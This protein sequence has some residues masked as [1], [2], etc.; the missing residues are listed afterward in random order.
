MCSKMLLQ[1]AV[2]T[3]IANVPSQQRYLLV[4][5][6]DNE[7]KKLPP[8]VRNVGLMGP[9]RSKDEDKKPAGKNAKPA[10]KGNTTKK[11]A[12]KP[13]VKAT[14]KPAGKKGNSA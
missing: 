13:V 9:F 6:D 11:P 3:Y 1:L 14:G 5:I 2:L 10:G 8:E 4:E 12:D 7:T